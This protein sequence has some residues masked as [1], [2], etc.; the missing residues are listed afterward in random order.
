MQ[1]IDLIG[2]PVDRRG[3]FVYL[4][5]FAGPGDLGRAP[6]RARLARIAAPAWWQVEPDTAGGKLCNGRDRFAPE[7][8]LAHARAGRHGM[9]VVEETTVG[10]H[11]LATRGDF[12]SPLIGDE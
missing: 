5:R 6:Y 4:W 2:D 3:A 9:D 12:S 8:A 10:A 11:T 7:A 1:T